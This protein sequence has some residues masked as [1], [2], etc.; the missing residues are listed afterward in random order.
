[1]LSIVLLMLDTNCSGQDSNP[2]PRVT[3]EALT[4]TTHKFFCHIIIFIILIINIINVG[5]MK[6]FLNK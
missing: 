3:K 2:S 5:H 1:M 6:I 4:T